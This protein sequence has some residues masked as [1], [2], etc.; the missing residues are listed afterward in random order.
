MSDLYRSALSARI[1]KLPDLP[2]GDDEDE[3]EEAADSISSLPGSGMGPPAL[4]VEFSGLSG[5]Q[6]LITSSKAEQTST[7][8]LKSNA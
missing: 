4:Q 7:K 5:L 3:S 1:A 8:G 2:P 6:C